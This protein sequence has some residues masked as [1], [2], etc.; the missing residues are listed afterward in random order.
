MG[1]YNWIMVAETCPACGKKTT[2]KAQTHVASDFGG[3]D[4]GRFCH[5]IYH[6]GDKMAWYPA[7]DGRFAR[8]RERRVLDQSTLNADID[9][10]ACYAQCLACGAQLFVVIRFVDTRV[11]CIVAIG[12]EDQWPAGYLK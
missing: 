6:L 9:E 11:D 4:S 3:D 1:A 2:I 5:R 8:W 10:E 12:R 7:G